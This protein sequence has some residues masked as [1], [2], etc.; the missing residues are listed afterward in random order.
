MLAVSVASFFA[1]NKVKPL[2]N[3]HR[4]SKSEYLCIKGKGPVGSF[5]LFYQIPCNDYS[6][7]MSWYLTHQTPLPRFSSPKDPTLSVK[8]LALVDTG[9]NDCDLKGSLIDSRHLRDRR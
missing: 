5:W 1:I 2:L 3:M 6:F 9:S 8:V 7:A 4:V